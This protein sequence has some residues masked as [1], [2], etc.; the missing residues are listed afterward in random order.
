[1]N[2]GLRAGRDGR[3]SG[4]VYAC[5]CLLLSKHDLLLLRMKSFV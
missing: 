1:M 2:A 3:L 5:Y 4:C